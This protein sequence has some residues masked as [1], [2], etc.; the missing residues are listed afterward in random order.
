[1][2]LY[3]PPVQVRDLSSDRTQLRLYPCMNFTCSGKIVKLMFI[4]PVE[5]DR[6]V[7]VRWPEF[8]LW[9]KCNRSHDEGC[10]WMEVKRLTTNPEEPCLVYMNESQGV[11]VYE[12]DLALN[13][14]M[15]FEQGNFLGIRCSTDSSSYN[16]RVLYQNDSGYCNALALKSQYSDQQINSSNVLSR[17][18]IIPYVAVETG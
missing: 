17:D 18:P 11:G 6:T 16:I 12:I 8:G 3:G 7:T 4:A 1:M 15:I 9:R 5:T 10:E 14:N 13:N 2:H